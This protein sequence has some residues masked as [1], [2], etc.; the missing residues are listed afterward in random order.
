[1]KNAALLSELRLDPDHRDQDRGRRFWP[2]ILVG[3]LLLTIAG[4]GYWYLS[5]KKAIA[6]ETVIARPISISENNITVLDA[7]GYVT[8]RRMSTVSAKITGKLREVLIE[9]GD[10]VKQGQVLARL[11]DTEAE[12]RLGVARAQVVAAR[13]RLGELQAQM[14]Q[15][16][17]D[18]DRQ[19]NLREYG[20]TTQELL[21]NAKTQVVSLEAQIKA[22]DSQIRVAEAQLRVDEVAY[23]DTVIRAPF[24]GVVIAKAAQP[25]EMVSPI[26]AGGGY[27]RTGIGTIVDMDSLEIEVDVN[28]AYINRVTPEQPV[29]AVLDAYPDWKMPGEVIAII[30][31]ADRSKATV[32]VRIGLKEKDSRIV[33][34]M[35]VK[36]SFLE[37]QGAPQS[38]KTVSGVLVPA[39]SIV[40]LDGKSIVFIV[41][42][43]LVESRSIKS[44][45][46]SGG[47]RVVERGIEAGETI[48]VDPPANLN[49]GMR[50]I[51]IPKPG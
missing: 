39:K 6:V 8:A 28:E 17:R 4:G 46:N 7:T 9:E 5:H 22:Q 40:Q 23:E 18:L 51:I 27:T 26:S 44:G 45:G 43:G 15:A 14:E 48:I 10:R 25:G 36:V 35:G 31:A 49:D 38:S 29:E 37:E 33:P 47:K 21:D 41:K 24:S 30:P 13:A 50:V 34:D 16:H 42:G 19:Q 3:I 12:A 11:D 2:W 32:K 20:L 1:M